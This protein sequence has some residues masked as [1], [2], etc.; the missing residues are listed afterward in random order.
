MVIPATPPTVPACCV[1]DGR[2]SIDQWR[3]GDGVCASRTDS[4]RHRLPIDRSIHSI[5]PKLTGDKL[6]PEVGRRHGWLGGWLTALF[7]GGEV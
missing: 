7:G 5:H 1:V 3:E 6:V 2:G 4:Q